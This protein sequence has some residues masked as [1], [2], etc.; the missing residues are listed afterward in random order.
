[1]GN[2]L[3][4]CMV[5]KCRRNSM[6]AMCG[7]P[8]H[9]R[10]TIDRGI[11]AP[12][13]KL[14]QHEAKIQLLL[15]RF[16]PPAECNRWMICYMLIVWVYMLTSSW[17]DVQLGGLGIVKR[18]IFSFFCL[19]NVSTE[20]ILLRLDRQYVFNTKSCNSRMVLRKRQTIRF[21]NLM[22]LMDGNYTKYIQRATWPMLN[23]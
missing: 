12:L 7:S 19:G 20:V 4:N 23:L 11:V 10:S 2:I 16:V 5:K 1:M 22:I 6:T 18:I 13:A 14:V 15:L 8:D 21:Y 17:G 3:T 9:N